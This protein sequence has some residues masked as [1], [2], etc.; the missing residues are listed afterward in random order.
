MGD[1][2]QDLAASPEPFASPGR[3]E[4]GQC[5][6]KC[7]RGELHGGCGCGCGFCW[8]SEFVQGRFV[9]G[10]ELKFE[11]ME[12]VGLD[13]EDTGIVQD[14]ICNFMYTYCVGSIRSL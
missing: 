12:N 1:S 3:C 7:K 13:L 2:G 5:Q 6:K 11:F 9:F 8:E 10:K 4:A 14:L